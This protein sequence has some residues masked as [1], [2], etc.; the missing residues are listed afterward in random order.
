MEDFT[1][2]KEAKDGFCISGAVHYGCRGP[3]AAFWNTPSERDRW[4]FAALEATKLGFGGIEYIAKVLDVLR[5][6]L[7]AEPTNLASCRPILLRDGCGVRVRRPDAGRKK[8]RV[9]VGTRTESESGAGGPFR[10][11]PQRERRVV[12][13]PLAAPDRRGGDGRGNA[14]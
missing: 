11:R 12:D 14:G 4:R 2:G 8:Y 5:L 3:N 9:R 7:S 6:P 1:S 10:R 13:G